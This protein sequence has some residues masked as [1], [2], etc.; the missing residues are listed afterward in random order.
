MYRIDFEIGQPVY[1][2]LFDNIVKTELEKIIISENG[3]NYKVKGSKWDFSYKESSK[4]GTPLAK[5][6]TEL[7]DFLTSNIRDLNA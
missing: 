3:I 4:F 1:F 6:S 2:L 5:S 7:V